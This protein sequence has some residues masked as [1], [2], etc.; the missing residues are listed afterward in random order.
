MR[1]QPNRPRGVLGLQGGQDEQN[2]EGASHWEIKTTQGD[3]KVRSLLQDQNRSLPEKPQF[4]LV[5]GSSSDLSI[6]PQP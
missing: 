1:T 5:L 4:L 6:L 2:I 3:K